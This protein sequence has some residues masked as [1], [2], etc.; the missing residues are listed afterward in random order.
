MA[1]EKATLSE[2]YNEN[3][4]RIDAV[5]RVD[6]SF[7]IIKK[8]MRFA[9]AE[10]TLYY[11]DGFVKA[12]LMQKLMMHFVSLKQLPA[13]VESF[14]HENVPAVEVDV[15][16]SVDQIVTMVLSGCTALLCSDYG[17]EAVIIDART[18]PARETS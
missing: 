6:D 14:V 3:I 1:T 5:L 9:G 2:S 8:T 18:Y 11:I 15:T 7:D 10:S 16:D 17:G 13:T 4:K 12:E